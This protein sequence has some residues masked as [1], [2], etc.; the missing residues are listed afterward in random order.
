MSQTLHRF[1]LSIILSAMTTTAFATNYTDLLQAVISKQP[2]QI[3]L[4]GL[5]TVEEQ[6]ND[7]AN[8]WFP[9]QTNLVVAHE[10]DGLTGNLD[11]QKWQ[12][13][14][15]VPLWLSGQKMAQEKMAQSYSN[16]QAKQNVY[17]RWQASAQ[18]RDLVWQYRSET[19]QKDIA[20]QRVTQ[21]KNLEGLIVQLVEA[22][23]KPKIDALLVQK[24]RLLA[25]QNLLEKGSNFTTAQTSYQAWT[26]TTA[27]PNSLLETLRDYSFENHPKLTQLTAEIELLTAEYLNVKSVRQDN[28]VLSLGGFHEDDQSMEGNTS[29]YAQVSY[30]IGDN[31][32]TSVEASQQHYE[33]LS[34]Q[35]ELERLKLELTNQIFA[36]EQAVQTSQKKL[37]LLQDQVIISE[38]TLHLA[39][40]TYQ[41]GEATVQLL[42]NAQ[43]ALLES[44]LQQAMTQIEMAK[45]IAQRNQIAGVSL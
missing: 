40:L 13:G 9:G 24:T 33:V 7:S 15:E 43:Q 18:L 14:V 23:E 25:E 1:S 8:Q 29:L 31:P 4:T 35:A 6:M 5:Q 32:S 45:A 3:S 34:K 38:Q 22:G 30:P 21:I 17:L 11:K 16:L 26:N 44:K 36:A 27:L 2:E 42:M 20:Q 12:V 19:V 39:Q 41:A 28:P 37:E 10:N